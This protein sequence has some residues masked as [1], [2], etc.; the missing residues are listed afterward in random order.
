MASPLVGSVRQIRN[1]FACDL[2]CAIERKYD[3]I[4]NRSVAT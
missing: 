1:G 3:S 4:N 2:K